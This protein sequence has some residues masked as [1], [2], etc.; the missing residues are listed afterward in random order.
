MEV[1]VENVIINVDSQADNMDLAFVSHLA[2]LIYAYFRSSDRVKRIAMIMMA[3][4][5]VQLSKIALFEE[6]KKKDEEG[7]KDGG[8]SRT[9]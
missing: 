2:G 9:S 3:D 4:A 6:T 7:G 5:G 1:R 8:V